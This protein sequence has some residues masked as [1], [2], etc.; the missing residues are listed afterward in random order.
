MNERKYD[1]GTDGDLIRTKR[2][3]T[4]KQ[5]LLLDYDGPEKLKQ[6]EV[7][8]NIQKEKSNGRGKTIDLTINK[9]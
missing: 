2:E 3:N 6:T 4:I 7:G 1:A 5:L 9:K 8:K